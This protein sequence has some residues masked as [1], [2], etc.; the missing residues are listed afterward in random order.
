VFIGRRIHAAAFL[1][2]AFLLQSPTSRGETGWQNGKAVD[3]LGTLSKVPLSGMARLACIW[4]DSCLRSCPLGSR[5][6]DNVWNGAEDKAKPCFFFSNPQK[7]MNQLCWCRNPDLQDFSPQ[8]WRCDVCSTLISKSFPATDITVTADED[9][10]FYGKKYWLDHQVDEL[11]LQS[12]EERSRS[13]FLDRCGWWLAELLEFSLPPARLLEIG[14]SHGGFLELAELAGF[15]VTGIELSP[16]VVEFARKSFGVDVR[17]GPIER[18]GFQSGSFD[19]ICMFDVLEHLQD[20]V[21]TLECCAQALTPN[22]VLLVQTPQYPVRTDFDKLQEENH[23]FLKMLLPDE[24]LFLFSAESVK[25]LLNEVGFSTYEFLPARFPQHDMMFVATKGLLSRNP[26]PAQ[27]EALERSA[28]GRVLQGFL[29]L[30]QQNIEWQSQSSELRA[31]LSRV[32]QDVEKL[33]EWLRTARAEANDRGKDAEDRLRLVESVS[34]EL[35]QRSEE[36]QQRSE[37]LRQRSEELRQKSEELRE[38]CAERDELAERATVRG[39]SRY[40]FKR[41][42][43]WIQTKFPTGE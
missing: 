26:D 11:G 30:F 29:A 12:I 43:S 38:V 21:R 35:G 20:P 18:Q 37:E 14:C 19:A 16:W 36:L 8:Y 5:R 6:D 28:A 42:I 17:T 39:L 25:K 10:D 15:S 13:D 22:G 33:N 4:D 34:D 3:S 2:R 27:K 23:P 1:K 40:L 31:S 41:L 24:H 7:L 9:G 32:Y